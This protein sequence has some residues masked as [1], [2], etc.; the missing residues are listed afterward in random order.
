MAFLLTTLAGLSTVLGAIFVFFN[1]KN[2]DKVIN[3]AL[4]FA[5]G[6]MIT[7]SLFDLLPESFELLKPGFLSIVFILLSI[8]IGI[9]LSMIIDKFVPNNDNLYRVGIISMI[10]IIMHNIPE[11]IATYMAGTHNIKLGITLS[12]AIALHNIPEGITVSL[13][14]YY[15]TRSKIKAFTYTLLSGVSEIF[16][17]ILAAIFLKSAITDSFMAILLGVISGIMFYISFYELLPEAIRYRKIRITLIASGVGMLIMILS[18]LLT[19]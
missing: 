18:I 2:E 4:S 14:I 10:A 16:G 9:I 17:A 3:I 11:G 13:P 12:I 8:N 19:G 15:S 6:V 1:F 7:V 5:A